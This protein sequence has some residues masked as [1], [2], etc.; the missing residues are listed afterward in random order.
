MVET[1]RSPKDWY[2][3]GLRLSPGAQMACYQFRYCVLL[4][5]GSAL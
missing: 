1:P 2:E 4:R 3:V 5:S